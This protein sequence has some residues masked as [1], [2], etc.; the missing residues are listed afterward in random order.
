MQTGVTI[1]QHAGRGHD[2]GDV[3]GDWADG[4]GAGER[5]VG[6]GRRAV[7]PCNAGHQI[8][9]TRMGIHLE[10]NSQASCDRI[11]QSSTGLLLH[12][13]FGRPA[14]LAQLTKRDATATV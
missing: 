7:R 13:T 2:E 1:F 6:A 5:G 4:G 12:T 3:R 11:G 14:R 8:N 9:K 10:N